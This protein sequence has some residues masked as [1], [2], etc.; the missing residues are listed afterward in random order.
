MADGK[1]IYCWKHQEIPKFGGIGGGI[2][3]HPGFY[4]A[5]RNIQTG[6]LIHSERITLRKRGAQDYY[7]EGWQLL[8]ILPKHVLLLDEPADG[9]PDEKPP[10]WKQTLES[11]RERYA[12]WLPSLLKEDTHLVCIDAANGKTVDRLSVPIDQ[13]PIAYYVPQQQSLYLGFEVKDGFHIL[14]YPY[15]FRKPW[16][17]ILAWSLGVFAILAC[18]QLFLRLTSRS[19]RKKQTV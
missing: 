14:Q 12:S 6:Q 7:P 19:L 10:Q 13:H 5:C 17:L 4:F 2:P 8:T 18:L 9:S 15:P 1:L 16:L 11:W 3:Y